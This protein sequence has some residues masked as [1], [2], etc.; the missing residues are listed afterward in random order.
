MVVH[1]VA[2]MARQIVDRV[3][4]RGTCDFVDDVAA[5]LPSYVI[6]ELLGIP[7][8][9]GRRL[10]ELTEIMNGGADG[11]THVEYSRVLDAQVQM[12][13]YGTAAAAPIF[14]LGA[15]LARVE[16]AAIIP[17]VLARMTDLALTGPVE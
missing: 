3:A 12:F 15:N 1:H 2:H 13:Q 14:C 9:D 5:A 6:A 8:E 4:E 7:L 11:D 10:Y 16:A 17:E